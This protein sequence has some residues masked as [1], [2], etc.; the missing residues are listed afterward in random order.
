MKNYNGRNVVSD[1]GSLGTQGNKTK[2]EGEAVSVKHDR[3]HGK[4][5]LL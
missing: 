2:P 1:L 4:E 5:K 3:G